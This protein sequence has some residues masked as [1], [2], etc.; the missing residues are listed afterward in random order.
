MSTTPPSLPATPPPPA[1][2]ATWT[3]SEQWAWAEILAGRTAN[4]NER[5]GL[6]PDPS[7]LTAWQ[8]SGTDRL[9]S[10]PFLEAI[11]KEPFVKAIPG[12]LSIVGAWTTGNLFLRDIALPG[13]DLS[14][15]RFDGDAMFSRA[16]IGG[17]MSLAS[18][19]I[20]GHLWLR[21]VTV[22]GSLRL[23]GNTVNDWATLDSIRVGADFSM[24]D[25]S[26][27]FYLSS[28]TVVSRPAVFN[29]G[30][31]INGATVDGT[32]HIANVQTKGIS[33]TELWVK[34]PAAITADSSEPINLTH[35]TFDQALRLHEV[36]CQHSI[37]CD[38]VTVKRDLSV[39]QVAARSL[40]LTHTRI[41]GAL[42]IS[43][44]LTALT[45]GKP[46][47]D[48]ALSLERIVV[49]SDASLSLTLGGMTGSNVERMKIGG[50][51]EL[52]VQ[53]E[54]YFNLSGSV[55]Q[56]DLVIAGSAFALPV[57]ADLIQVSGSL[58][59]ADSDIT[60][61]S[62]AG[63][64][65]ERDLSL[66]A[67]LK[68][69]PRWAEHAE[70]DLH[71]A[72]VGALSELTVFS[73][74]T[75]PWPPKLDLRGF[76]LSKMVAYGGF[77]HDRSLLSSA[78][79]QKWLERDSSGSVQAYAQLA[80]ILK[81]GGEFEKSNDILFA[82]RELARREAIRNGMRRRWLGLSLL[83]WT[84]GYGLGTRYFRVLWWVAAF[85][86]VG[87][88]TLYLDQSLRQHPLTTESQTMT[89]MTAA[90][91]DALLP[92]V[93]LDKTFS[94]NIPANL[95]FYAKVVFWT[96]GVAGWVLGAFLA[97]GLAGLTQKPS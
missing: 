7:Q 20:G 10:A 76:T 22:Q 83:K 73:T 56:G 43:G 54:G 2:L 8:A 63:A 31:S 58:T 81:D 27:A 78:E 66:G 1:P 55:V 51:L 82:G 23:D 4:F 35:A 74:E 14:E 52:K 40:F 95:G 69:P 41:D 93:T 33:F 3:A 34:G 91:I 75:D 97:A 16:S 30:L 65:V 92:I 48:L 84:I 70:L 29:G 13:I 85:V 24:T 77:R 15:C 49:G 94:D 80:K 71:N 67:V 19:W 38:G 45:S 72:S 90:S 46:L 39:F 36:K 60:G 87:V 96:L 50:D 32:L 47:G 42:S 11:L 9:L 57:A 61:I 79:L 86:A 17:E 25:N 53:C 5:L 12:A 28:G 59:I 68:N 26:A 89:W 18:S 37:A 6:S 88:A 62:L 64:R 44:S 21:G